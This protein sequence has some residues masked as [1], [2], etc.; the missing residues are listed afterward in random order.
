MIRVTT[1]L[2]LALTLAACGGSDGTTDVGDEA[3]IAVH[4]ATNV[5]EANAGETLAFTA[6]VTNSGPAEAQDVTLTHHLGGP[7]TLTGITCSATG[8]ATCP[9]DLGPEMKIAHLPVGGGLLFDISVSTDAEQSGTVTSSWIASSEHDRD[10]TNNVGESSVLMLDLRNGD[11]TAY[12][13]NGRQYTLSLDF[14][15]MTYEMNG[16]QIARSGTIARSQDGVSYL[17]DA[18]VTARFRTTKDMVVGGFDFNLDDSKHPYDHGVRPF[19]AARKFSTVFQGMNWVPVNL[20]G[21]NLRRNDTVESIVY[22]SVI[23]EGAGLLSCRAPLPVPVDQCPAQFL[24]SYALSVDGDQIKGVDA[25]HS[26]MIHFRFAVS[27]EQLLL[28]RAED[29]AD[30]SGRHFRMGFFGAVA[31]PPG[32]F[33]TSSSSS[34]SGT[35]TLTETNYEF[36]GFLADGKPFGYK[37]SLVPLIGD[38]LTHLRQGSNPEL[39]AFYLGQNDG[40]MMMLGAPDGLSE[41]LMDIGLQ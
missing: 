33:F 30:A 27:G 37:S 11:Y 22:P 16:Q 32:S 21:L 31:T 7:A 19:V 3:E 8:G 24:Y 15:R 13:S 1:S 2:L 36:S 9:A 20:M 29:A 5:V 34:A 35:T 4:G 23:V 14:N 38:G 26:D 40:L 18:A 39:G 17:F 25:A 28:L 12:G 6:T 41:G 10:L